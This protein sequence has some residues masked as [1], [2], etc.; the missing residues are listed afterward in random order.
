MNVDTV[1]MNYCEEELVKAA[2]QGDREAFAVLYEANVGRVYH[3]L[4][5]RVSQPADAEDVTAEVFIRAMK[6]LRSYK[7]ESTEGHRWTA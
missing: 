7:P 6:A 5:G 3:Y 4:L 2:Q 1:G